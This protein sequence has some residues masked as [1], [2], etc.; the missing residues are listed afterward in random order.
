MLVGEAT[1]KLEHLAGVPLQPETARRLHLLYLAKGALATTA[2]EGNTLTEEEV[3]KR[4]QGKLELPASKEY[5]G[6]EIDNIVK[7]CNAILAEIEK[8]EGIEI[9]LRRIQE[10]NR[11]VLEGLPLRDEVSPGVT[12]KHSVG[13]AAY[14]G[15]PVEDCEFLLNRLCEWLTGPEWSQQLD[16]P[17][18]TAILKAILAHLY[19]AWI[20]PFGDGNGRTA[21]LLEYQL[22]IDAGVPTPAAHLLSNHYNQTRAEYYRQLDRASQSG[23]DVIPFLVY[24]LQGFVDGLRAQIDRIRLQQWDVSW[25]NYVH[26]VFRGKTSQSDLRRRQLVLDLSHKPDGVPRAELSR[27]SPEVASLYAR[28]TAKTLS[29]DINALI[30]MGLIEWREGVGYRAK[31]ETI[32]AFLPLRRQPQ[33]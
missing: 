22:L 21:R 1:S 6:Q 10:F 13:V 17:L 27:V 15:A 29:R 8:G 7:A 2:I 20:H 14:R 25:Q 24:A 32:L 30:E 26:D 19:I 18:A 12:R 33:A 9:S 23:G 3:I 11:Q 28:K 31:M 16:A 5:L 4:V